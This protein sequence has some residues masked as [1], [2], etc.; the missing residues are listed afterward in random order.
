M[1]ECAGQQQRNQI[2]QE[3]KALRRRL[4]S[5]AVVGELCMEFFERL[6]TWCGDQGLQRFVNCRKE[7]LKETGMREQRPRCFRV[8]HGNGRLRRKLVYPVLKRLDG[9]RRCVALE[10]STRS[11]Q[12]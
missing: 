1:H 6:P 7:L 9:V 5:R 10:I 12:Y 2:E 11:R 3:P 4:D 8:R